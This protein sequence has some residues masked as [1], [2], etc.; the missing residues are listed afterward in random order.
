MSKSLLEQMSDI[1]ALGRQQAEKLLGRQPA[2]TLQA[3]EWVMRTQDGRGSHVPIAASPGP[4]YRKGHGGGDWANRLIDG[5]SLAAMAMLLAGDGH[6]PSLRNQIDLIYV[7]PP[8]VPGPACAMRAPAQET[9]HEPAAADDRRPPLWDSWPSDAASYLARITPQLILMRELL[10]ANGSIFVHLDWHV[11]HY[12]KLILDDLFGPGNFR[13]EIV[14][15]NQASHHLQI[16]R[17][18]LLWYTKTTARKF[19]PLWLQAHAPDGPEDCWDHFWSAAD[20]PAMRYNLFGITP[21]LGHWLWPEARALQA[22]R[23]YERFCEEGHGRSIGKYW[24]DTGAA[25]EFLR[26][27]PEDGVPQCWRKPLDAQAAAA[28]HAMHRS[29]GAT[30]RLAGKNE[31]YLAQIIEFAT[32]ESGLVAGFGSTAA[33]TAAVAE[34]LGRRWLVAGLDKPAGASARHRLVDQGARAFLHQ[35]I[36]DEHE[37]VR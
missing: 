19:P 12:V 6:A 16:R 11:A 3:S 14:L 25:L 34:K 4:A 26:P 33:S 37:S 30:G 22:A 24:H 2:G 18:Q 23:N 35:S 13:N 8:F 17:D 31:I 36:A 7:E 9:A 20:R 29:S 15:P 10:D 27:S 5:R 21:T 1:V 32:A 28:S